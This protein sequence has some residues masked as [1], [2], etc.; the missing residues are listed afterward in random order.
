MEKEYC[1]LAIN[2]GSTSTKIA[3]FVNEVCE[4]E[5]VIR[6]S[7]EDLLP[8]QRPDRDVMGQKEMRRRL[9]E[10]ALAEKQIPLERLDAVVGRAGRLP[11]MPGGTYQV[12]E[13]LLQDVP[14]PLVHP[15]LLGAL[16]AKDLGDA[17]GIPS[18]FVD[19]TVVD[20]LSDIARI[21]GIPEISRG[22]IFHALNHKAVARRYA[23]EH[24]TRYEDT[25]LIIAHMGGGI[26][27]AAHKNGLAVDV[28][29]A[30]NGEG[31]MSP[32]RAGMVPGIPLVD[33]CF[34]G[35][36][37][38]QEMRRFFTQRGGLN[39]YLGHSDFR[40]CSE[41]WAE[42]KQPEKNLFEAMAYQVS[43]HICSMAAILDGKVDAVI[44]T[45]GLAYSK[46]FIK[47][48]EQRVRFLGDVVVYPGED[49]LLSLA[50][51]ALRVLRGEEEARRYVCRG[52]IEE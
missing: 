22:V 29:N 33:L 21:T 8:Y 30:S 24:G 51:G 13:D 35:N 37:T 34:S 38:H 20:E 26:S 6:H 27:I 47:L 9:V 10:Q 42:G 52:A 46:D 41:G 15:A 39:A 1:V 12:T 4:T 11:P 5:V 40:K 19:P 50:Q 48:I 44:L 45:G 23:A 43:K 17:L 32:E 14:H 36:Y 49:E 18:F 7:K 31:P 3:V 25:N 16:I 28:T 2:P